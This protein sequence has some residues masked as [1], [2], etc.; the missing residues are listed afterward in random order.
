MKSDGDISQ[1]LEILFK[2]KE[3][4]ASLNS[5]FRTPMEVV[6]STAR[7]AYEDR[8]LQNYVPLSN[9]LDR[10]GQGLYQRVTP[11]GYSMQ[12]ICGMAPASYFGALRWC[13]FLVV[14]HRDFSI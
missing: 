3:F 7:L 8:Q 6:V 9:S 5:K 2:S 10:L 11:D 14:G 1:T 12:K 13:A 4:N